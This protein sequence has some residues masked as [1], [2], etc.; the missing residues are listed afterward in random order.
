MYGESRVELTPEVVR[1]CRYYV[2]MYEDSHNETTPEVVRSCR[3]E[4]HGLLP[5]MMS[6]H[7]FCDRVM[8]CKCMCS[9]MYWWHVHVPVQVFIVRLLQHTFRCLS[10]TIIVGTVYFPPL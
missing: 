2:Y 5:F 4:Y 7:K 6:F 1:T 10:A 8:L 3:Y 9:Y